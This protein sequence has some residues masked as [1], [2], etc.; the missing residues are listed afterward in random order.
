MTDLILHHYAISAFSE[1]VRL[2]MG[3][4]HLRYRSVEIPRMMP[5]PDLVALTGGYRRTPV[6]Q[7]G[8]DIYCDTAIILPTI[9][10]LHPAPSLYP[11]GEGVVT[12]LAWWADKAL[13]PRA[14]AVIGNVNASKL[15]PEFVAERK[16]FGFNLDVADIGPH[17]PHD[18][19]QAN[20]EIARLEAMLHDGRSFLLGDA[21]SAADFA[22]YCSIWLL[23]KQ[24]GEAAGK[25]VPLDG[26]S[27]WSDR[28]AAIGHGTPEELS[29][30]EAL[31]IAKSV[32]P[33]APR[34]TGTA[35][36]LQIGQ[37]VL[38]S[39]NDTGRDAVRGELVTANAQTIVIRRTSAELGRLHLHFP[40]AGFVVAPA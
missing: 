11:H 10:A 25:L 1:R 18:C 3:L 14:L 38:V 36:G 2:T 35:A 16:A 9:E 13:F 19:D 24:G 8:A 26:I 37:T 4:K 15:S 5:K 29:S 28:V 32:E 39:P 30:T 12:A 40:R 21:P 17:F 34:T 20:A 31:A 23:Q 7:I 27:M 33:L 6:L 22:A